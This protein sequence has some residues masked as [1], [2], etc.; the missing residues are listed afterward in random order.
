MVPVSLSGSQVPVPP[1]G[2]WAR[3]AAGKRDVRPKLPPR[4]PGLGEETVVGG[5]PYW[6]YHTWTRP[7]DEELLGPIP[8]EPTFDEPLEAVCV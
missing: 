8:P 5:G 7:S 3:K 1:R 4:P 6:R 2:Y